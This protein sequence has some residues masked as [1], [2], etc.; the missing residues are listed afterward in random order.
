[1]VRKQHDPGVEPLYVVELESHR[2]PVSEHV[3]VSVAPN[4]RVRLNF[5]SLTPEREADHARL[6]LVDALLD[7]PL[8]VGVLGPPACIRLRDSQLE[9]TNG[10]DWLATVGVALASV[11]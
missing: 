7:D 8:L 3:D 5:S 4:E 6:R 1:V 9:A 11:E 10:G 2:S